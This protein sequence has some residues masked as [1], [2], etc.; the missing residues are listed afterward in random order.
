MVV[1]SH[2]KEFVEPNLD[3]QKE[4]RSWSRKKIAEVDEEVKKLDQ[5]AAVDYLTKQNHLI[6][7]HFNEATKKHMADLVT[8]GA[9]MSKLTFLMDP[10]L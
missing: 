4:L 5:V 9:E 6:A 2:Y 7:E 8:K 1:E 3:Y 10:N